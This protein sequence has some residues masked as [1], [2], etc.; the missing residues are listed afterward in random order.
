MKPFLCFAP[1]ADTPLSDLRNLQMAV[2]DELSKYQ[3]LYMSRM[4]I[5][6]QVHVRDVLSLHALNHILRYVLM[7][8]MLI[9]TPF[10]HRCTGRGD[11]YSEIT[12]DLPTRMQTLQLN[13]HR[14]SVT[15]DSLAHLYLFSF[16]SVHGHYAGSNPLR[17]TRQSQ[18]IKLRITLVY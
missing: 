2:L 1:L 8:Y 17:R 12:S 7:V 16:P 6:T 10:I 5:E 11:G 18:T 13:H 3:D 15:K 9:M 14:K 4:N